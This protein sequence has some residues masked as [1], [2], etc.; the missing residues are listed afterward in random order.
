MSTSAVSQFEYIQGVHTRLS[1]LWNVIVN[2]NSNSV[3]YKH[4]W[5]KKIYEVKLV[6]EQ[7]QN[8]S[9]ALHAIR[10]Q[11]QPTIVWAI[12][13]IQT[14]GY[15]TMLIKDELNGLIEFISKESLATVEEEEETEESREQ[16]ENSD[17]HAER[18]KKLEHLLEEVRKLFESSC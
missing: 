14:S 11:V 15:D 13:N 16:V 7:E 8:I 2:N 1:Q 17:A 6:L 4:W 12:K 9:T 3:V 5:T 18:S 10:S